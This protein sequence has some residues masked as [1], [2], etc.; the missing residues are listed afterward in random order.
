M[1]ESDYRMIEKKRDEASKAVSDVLDLSKQIGEREAALAILK[2]QAQ[3][4]SA[5]PWA[6]L[7]SQQDSPTGTKRTAVLIGTMNSQTDRAGVLEH[8]RTE[9]SGNKCSP[10]VDVLSTDKD[11]TYLTVMCVSKE[12]E[13][14]LKRRS[15][16]SGYTRT[17]AIARDSCGNDHK[18]H[19]NRLRL[20]RR[21]SMN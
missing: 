18:T 1:S 13:P 16:Q 5:K 6:A 15:E 10:D 19:Q 21:R 11:Y 12:I 2:V 17:S 3:I 9:M 7:R 8:N 20:I 14:R 4:E